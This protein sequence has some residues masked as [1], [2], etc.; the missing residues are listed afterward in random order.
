MSNFVLSAFADEISPKL[1][2]QI[3]VLL[4][5]NVRHIELR[6]IDGKNVSKF[7]E[8]E[9]KEYIKEMEASGIAVS[10]M[11]SPIGK[12]K[13]DDPFEPHLDEF[14][15]IL[16]LSQIFKTKYIRMFSFYYPLE[17]DPEMYFDA[18]LERWHKFI[19]AAK[20]YD[21]ILLHE[22]EKDIYGDISSRC[23]KLLTTINNPKVKAIFDPANFIFSNEGDV[24]K[25]YELLK[26]YIEY[27]HIKDGDTNI[28]RVVPAGMGEGDVAII[29]KDAKNSGF[30]GFL[31]LEPH[32][33]Y[34][35]GLAA[36]EKHMDVSKMEKGGPQLF[37][38]AY[39]ALCDILE[40]I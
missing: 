27:F 9:S 30:K 12:I 19:E 26:P 28:G 36:F 2:E 20:G 22:N 39:K 32:L 3:D 35:D 29:L 21:V 10:C 8:A 13:I 37:M 6:G 7:T 25:A 4:K 23:H 31:S 33:G 40:N 1:S 34:F 38:I 15:H 11:G 5:T 14:K 16:E 18:V 17:N 24:F